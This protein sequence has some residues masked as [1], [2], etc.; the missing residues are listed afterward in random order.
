MLIR[1]LLVLLGAIAFA[2]VAWFALQQSVRAPSPMPHGEAASLPPVAAPRNAHAGAATQPSEPDAGAASGTRNS[3]PPARPAQAVPALVASTV[4]AP[5]GQLA[6]PVAGVHATQLT[7]SF[8]DLRGGSR[9][10]E[11]LDIAAP[12]GTPVL[13]VADG[14]VEKLFDSERGGLT[15]Y[16]FE[17]SGRYAYYYAHLQR[18]APGLR[19]GQPLRRGQVIGY[20]GSSGNADPA[21]PHLHFAVFELEPAREWWRGRPVNPYRLLGGH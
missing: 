8:A 4:D 21:A 3:P 11:A 17:P 15:L 13:A 20:V 18:Y 12:A 19:E 1:A 6:I 14:H 7:D 2:G 16:Q 10:H 5:G 9:P